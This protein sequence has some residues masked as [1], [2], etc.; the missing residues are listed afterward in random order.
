MNNYVKIMPEF[1]ANPIWDKDGLMMSWADFDLQD[2]HLLNRL[3]VWNHEWEKN[4]DT[5][6]G[7]FSNKEAI[8]ARGLQLAKYVKFYKASWTVMY[9]TEDGTSEITV[10]EPMWVKYDERT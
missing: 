1:C 6:T 10:A 3:A 7:V 2:D 8:E 4:Q 9:Y 5:L